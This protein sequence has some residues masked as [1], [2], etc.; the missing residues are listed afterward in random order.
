MD[1]H[2]RIHAETA[3]F[4]DHRSRFTIIEQRQHHQDCVSPGDP[5]LDDLAGVN[6]EVLGE[7]RSVELAPSGR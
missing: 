1:F 5:R 2:Q 6:E 3:R 7:D 4:R